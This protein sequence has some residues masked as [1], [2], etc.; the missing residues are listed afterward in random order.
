[1]LCLI[2][3]TNVDNGLKLLALKIVLKKIGVYIN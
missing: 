1:M 2:S 3:I